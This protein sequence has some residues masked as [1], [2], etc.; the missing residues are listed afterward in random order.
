MRQPPILP[1]IIKGTFGEV[2]AKFE[3]HCDER[4]A[5]DPDSRQHLSDGTLRNYKAII[6]WAHATLG[7]YRIDDPV[8]GMRP[9]LAQDAIDS[10]ADKPGLQSNA[11]ALLR[12]LDEWAAPREHLRY[13]IA[14]GVKAPGSEGGHTPWSDAQATYGEQHAPAP[15][16]RAIPLMAHLGQRGSDIV[17]MRFSDIEEHRHPLTGRMYP[18][19]NVVTKKVGLK[20]WVPFTEPLIELVREW[21]RDARPPWYLLAKPDGQPY[22]RTYLSWHWWDERKDIEP[23]A[24]LVLHGLRGT[25]VVRYRKGGATTPE[26]CA[27]IGMSAP[28][29][30]RYCRFADRV[31]L[32]IAAVHRLS[33]GTQT[34][35][36]LFG[37]GSQTS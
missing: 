33:L 37:D 31:D 21:R 35:R 36:R 20:L 2:L 16:D 26:I 19:I 25:C 1:R 11:C 10:L 9:K 13:S 18:G 34:E 23:L 30:D 32:A 12:S 22:A 3:Q 15:F 29:V 28:M 24:D 4:N 6:R 5:L 17:R 14:R 7:K 8:A 27:T